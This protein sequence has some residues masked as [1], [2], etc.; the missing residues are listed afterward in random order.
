M[1][2]DVSVGEE[3]EMVDG[4]AEEAVESVVVAIA[5]QLSK[6]KLK[7]LFRERKHEWWPVDLV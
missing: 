6:S 2:L 5:Y 7:S 4:G 1:C 3:V